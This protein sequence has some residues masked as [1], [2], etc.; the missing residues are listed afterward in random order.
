M[1]SPSANLPVP[2][3]SLKI[4]VPSKAIELAIAD[5]TKL[6]EKSGAYGRGPYLYLTEAQRYEVG[7]RAAEHGTT[8]TIRYYA[9]KYRDVPELCQ[10]KETTV[11]R[12]KNLYKASL[13]QPGPPK[14]PDTDDSD[15]DEDTKVVTSKVKE[16]PR[17]TI[18]YWGGT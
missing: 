10:L 14:K 18:A 13:L 15:E 7:K 16:L 6:T 9:H 12:L 11:R 5:V 1:A 2:S 17:K 8:D 3:I 4:R